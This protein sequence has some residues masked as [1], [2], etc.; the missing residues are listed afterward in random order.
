MKALVILGFV[1]CKQFL[2]KYEVFF[3]KN[4]T[5]FLPLIFLIFLKKQV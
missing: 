2:Q 4:I 1:F 3:A 5:V